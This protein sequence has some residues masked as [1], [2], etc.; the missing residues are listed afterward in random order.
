MKGDAVK[1]MTAIETEDE[2]GCGHGIV[3]DRA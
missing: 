1:A 3:R 2:K